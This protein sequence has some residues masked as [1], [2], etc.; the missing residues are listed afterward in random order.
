MSNVIGSEISVRNMVA[1]FDQHSEKNASSPIS[2]K[3]ISA[4]NS[5]QH[6]V[7]PPVQKAEREPYKVV[8][9]SGSPVK[10]MAKK[11]DLHFEGKKSSP[12]SQTVSD[13]EDSS[14][15]V[16]R[17]PVQ[18]SE[19]ESRTGTREPKKISPLIAAKIKEMEESS[20]TANKIKVIRTGS[21]GVTAIDGSKYRHEGDKY[22]VPEIITEVDKSKAFYNLAENPGR[23]IVNPQ[24]TFYWGIPPGGDKS[25]SGEVI[26]PNVLVKKVVKDFAHL[27]TTHPV[28]KTPITVHDA[29][30]LILEES[31][32]ADTQKVPIKRWGSDESGI[33]MGYD[34]LVSDNQAKPKFDLSLSEMWWDGTADIETEESVDSTGNNVLFNTT[35]SFLGNEI[36]IAKQVHQEMEEML[37]ELSRLTKE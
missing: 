37:T 8:A 9:Y 21:S 11:F 36:K 17:S 16:V 20:S 31:N 28:N 15:Y 1:L 25:K 10:D 6:F 18:K 35:S 32:S 27:Q 7:R 22:K 3:V 19:Q 5:S 33:D 4:K 29:P 26:G 14:Q 2:Q 13:T 30:K 12:L 24:G 23:N 34:G